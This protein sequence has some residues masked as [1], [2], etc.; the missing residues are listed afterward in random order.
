MAT[1][2]DLPAELLQQLLQNFEDDK[3][4]LCQLCLVSPLFAIVAQELL[5]RHLDLSVDPGPT[6]IETHFDK[7]IKLLDEKPDL[8]K[9]VQ[10]LTIYSPYGWNQSLDSIERTVN[11]LSRATSLRSLDFNHELMAAEHEDHPFIRFLKASPLPRLAKLRIRNPFIQWAI[12]LELLHLPKLELLVLDILPA[13]PSL[14]VSP[15]LSFVYPGSPQRTC[16]LR[17]LDIACWRRQLDSTL[18]ELLVT[19][20]RL[21]ELTL[22]I[23]T[24]EFVS[25]SSFTCIPSDVTKALKPVQDTLKVLNITGPAISPAGDT[26]RL[27]LSAFTR[28]EKVDVI[29]NF[30]FTDDNADDARDGLYKLLPQSLLD[31]R[32]SFPSIFPSRTEC[33]LIFK[34]QMIFIIPA[35]VVTLSPATLNWLSE[36]AVNKAACFPN[37]RNVFLGECY[38]RRFEERGCYKWGFKEDLQAQLDDNSIATQYWVRKVP[39]DDETSEWI[40]AGLGIGDLI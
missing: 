6:G 34:P 16:W 7:V 11:L 28:L 10:G 33:L 18:N 31:L 13:I 25:A 2:S 36:L 23:E 26:S 24:E 12:F 29:S 37:L 38:G 40:Q 4:T 32:V 5:L 39:S 1:I 9:H 22:R 8:S 17:K 20:T 21:E 19:V 15:P 30:F 35:Q 14:T 3:A 27:D